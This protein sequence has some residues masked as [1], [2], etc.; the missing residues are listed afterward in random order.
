MKRIAFI[1]ICLFSISSSCKKEIPQNSILGTTTGKQNFKSELSGSR[2]ETYDLLF[3][4][5]HGVISFKASRP[6][7][8]QSSTT[9]H[10]YATFCRNL[11]ASYTTANRV[12]E[13]V[14]RVKIDN[15]QLPIESHNGYLVRDFSESE[16][17][18]RS[19]YGNTVNFSIQ[20]SETSGYQAQQT[21]LYIPKQLNAIFNDNGQTYFGRPAISRNS[22]LQL[23]WTADASNSKGV[24]IRI[25]NQYA[26][27]EQGMPDM[28]KYVNHATNFILADDDGDYTF[29]ADDFKDIPAKHELLITVMRGNAIITAN[30]NR[31]V[32]LY[33]GEEVFCSQYLIND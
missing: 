4:D 30:T 11:W 13:N 12:Y 14:G 16:N 21:Q 29:T 27:N 10:C 22:G 24:V 28:S 26:I 20:G 1:L 32:K 6:Y 5:T 8:N 2:A 23:K 18:F 7:Q 33:G 9:W 25:E 3:E 31:K 15:F 17:T 19:F